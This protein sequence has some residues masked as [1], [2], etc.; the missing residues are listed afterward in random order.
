MRFFQ[1]TYKLTIF[2]CGTLRGILRLLHF[3]PLFFIFM[4][5]C[6]IQRYFSVTSG[7]VICFLWHLPSNCLPVCLHLHLPSNCGILI[8][9]SVTYNTCYAPCGILRLLSA[10]HNT[11]PCC[12][13]RFFSVTFKCVFETPFPQSFCRKHSF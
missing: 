10:T 2:L 7:C 13:L 5:H 9:L 12:I 3:C 1:V 6:G 4:P 8:L 11:A